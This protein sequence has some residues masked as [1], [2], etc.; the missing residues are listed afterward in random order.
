MKAKLS[1]YL[2]ASDP[3]PKKARKLGSKINNGSL[4]NS[5]YNSV[6]ELTSEIDQNLETNLYKLAK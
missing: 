6:I 3:N 1:L 2:E 5:R 4:R